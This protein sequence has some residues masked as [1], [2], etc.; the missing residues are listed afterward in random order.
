MRAHSRAETT[1]WQPADEARFGP[2]VV[3]EWLGE[4]GLSVVH[5]ALNSDD[6]RE[7][8]LKRLAAAHASDWQLVDAFLHEAQLVTQLDHPNIAS[9]YE[10]GKR[11]GQ[12]YSAVEL[13]RGATLAA[14]AKQSHSAAGAIPVGVV[15]EIALQLCDVLEYLHARS[16]SVVHGGIA[17][18]NL[19]VSRGGRV[20]MIDFG[21]ASLAA[22]R[23]TRGGGKLALAYVAPEAVFGERDARGDLFALGVVAH[24]LLTGKPLFHAASEAAAVH[25]V[26]TRHISPPSRFAPSVSR[27]LDDIVLT[28]LQRDPAQR[29]QSAAAM[30]VALAAVADDLGGRARLVQHVRDWLAWA[31][32]QQP[33]RDSRVLHALDAIERAYEE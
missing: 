8:A 1:P 33:L 13:V 17:P 4:G 10:Y 14:V 9:V 25:N 15:V 22:R 24:E 31:F 19:M 27:E 2:Y 21:I 26:C 12:F 6:Q 30:R 16:P 5:R 28:A 29:W 32:S 18:T 23:K 20:K 7:V 11:G 3:H